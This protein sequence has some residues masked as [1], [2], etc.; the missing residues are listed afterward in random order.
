MTGS[1][2]SRRCRLNTWLTVSELPLFHSFPACRVFADPER[3][4]VMA[5]KPRVDEE[6]FLDKIPMTFRDFDG[7]G[8]VEQAEPVLVTSV[9]IPLE[10]AESV[11]ETHHSKS[12][13]AKPAK[14]EN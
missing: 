11:K 12:E 14:K 8:D 6:S 10:S 7:D 3:G 1:L 5:G 13:A 9:L 4:T 2:L